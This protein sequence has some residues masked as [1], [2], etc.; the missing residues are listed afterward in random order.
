M[1]V[2]CQNQTIYRPVNFQNFKNIFRM[3]RL[4]DRQ[5]LLNELDLMLKV[6]ASHDADESDIDEILEL[7]EIVSS[8]RYLNL[9]QH[10]AKNRSM[11]DRFH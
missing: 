10:I 9:R 2:V 3:P 8:C 4:S 7:K 6:M 5:N 11:E 1:R